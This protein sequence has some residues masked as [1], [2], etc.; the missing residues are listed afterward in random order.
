MTV[1]GGSGTRRRAGAA[2]AAAVA[3]LL[4]AACFPGGGGE[5]AGPDL[6]RPSIAASPP[7]P[8]SV[9][10]GM[11]ALPLAAYGPSEEL[12]QRRFQAVRVLTARCMRQAGYTSY[13]PADGSAAASPAAGATA[14]AG[15]GAAAATAGAGAADGSDGVAA[16]AFGYLGEQAEIRGFHTARTG[17]ARP[18]PPELSEAEQTASDD[19]ARRGL[20][21]IADGGSKAAE[22]YQRLYGESLRATAADPRVVAATA[23]WKDCMARSGVPA[24]DPQSLAARYQGAG[25]AVTPQE[26]AAARADR[27][28]TAGTGLAGVWFAVLAGYQRGQLDRHAGELEPLKQAHAEQ[29]RRYARIIATGGE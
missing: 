13:D 20:E 14:G 4:C 6:P 22:L 23:A 21:R 1:R 2:L 19:C 7:P 16:G 27:D 18:G 29:D 9:R 15:A 10:A 12:A 11:A 3:A 26:L 24:E 5:P 8:P 25:T 28:C 17:Q